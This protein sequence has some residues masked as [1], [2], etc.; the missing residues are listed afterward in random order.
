VKRPLLGFAALTAAAL[1]PS[2]AAHVTAQPA[3][4]PVGV[5]ASVSFDSPNER[6]RPMTSLELVAPDGVELVGADAPRGWSAEVSGRRATFTGGSLPTEAT[7]L[8]PV[9]LRASGEPRTAVFR[10]T[11]RFD[12]GAVVR[13]ETPL[14]LLPGST[15]E[16]PSE[17]PTRALVA[18]VVGIAVIAGSLLLVRRLRRRT[19]QEG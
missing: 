17:H 7:L 11:Q 1:V 3:F 4:V 16:D 2:A 9:R 19:L 14:T 13:W 6:D 10:A 15:A 18:A 8:F 5:E 12:D